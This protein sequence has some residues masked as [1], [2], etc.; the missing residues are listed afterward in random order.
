[1]TSFI[2]CVLLAVLGTSSGAPSDEDW[3]V[4]KGQEAR[5]GEL[6]YVAHFGDGGCTASILNA[7]TILTAG[8]CVCQRA[9]TSIAV[10]AI[11]I[12]GSNQ[13][14]RVAQ[15]IIHPNY[16]GMCPQPGAPDIA[17]LKLASPIAFNQ[18]VRPIDINCNAI[19]A[20]QILWVMGYGRDEFGRSGVLKYAQSGISEVD[21]TGLLISHA[22]RYPS[23]ILPGDSG[24]PVALQSGNT[25][26]QVAVNS[27]GGGNGA[28]H[29]ALYAPVAPACSFIRQ[30]M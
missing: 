27:G 7:N 21:R 23:H 18:N 28:Q 22:S 13:V 6:P 12:G 5:L 3:R 24:G 2:L 26:V 8:H 9:P 25:V 17:I 4:L 16:R 30:Y 14:Y 19:R 1:M 10:G 15:T 29:V 11:R 20:G